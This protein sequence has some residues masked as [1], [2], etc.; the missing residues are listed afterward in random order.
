MTPLPDADGSTRPNLDQSPQVVGGRFELRSE[1]GRGGMGIVYKALD[2]QLGV[3]VAL[4]VLPSTLTRDPEDEE[5]LKREILTA[6]RVSHRNVIRI[7]EFGLDGRDP[8]IAMEYLTGGSLDGQLKAGLLTIPRALE[9]AVGLTEGLAAAHE[10]GVIHRDIKPENVLFDDAGVPRLVDFGLARLSD[11]SKRSVGFS[12]TP[13]YMSPE[14]GDGGEITFASDVYSLGVLFFQMFTGRL[15]FHADSLVRLA[16]LHAKEKPPSPST[17][18]PEI[19]GAIAALILDM[20]AKTPAQ[21]PDVNAVADRLHEISSLLGQSIVR[22]RTSSV[23]QLPSEPPPKRRRWI[24]AL[25]PLLLVGGAGG[26]ATRPWWDPA[27]SDTPGPLAVATASI[28]ETPEPTP[29]QVAFAPTTP[30]ATRSPAK[31]VATATPVPRTGTLSVTSYPS[32][33]EVWVDGMQV[34]KQTPLRKHTLPA[35]AHTVRFVNAALNFA[36]ESRV[37][38]TADA[39]TRLHVNAATGAVEKR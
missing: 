4:K 30:R 19:P 10:V 7:N 23:T 34:S 12:G 31:I 27:P 21:R 3:E 33:V 8:F 22:R 35:G 6:R 18:R 25:L 39:D 2:R 24:V 20:L 32:S 1:L 9:I 17:L 16:V 36:L 15:P 37:E 5:R 14:Q 26:I 38:L 28:A 29:T 13:F 11:A